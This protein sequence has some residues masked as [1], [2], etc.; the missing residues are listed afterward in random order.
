MAESGGGSDGVGCG[1]FDFGVGGDGRV[2]RED[3]ATV[4]IGGV[5]GRI[6]WRGAW[7]CRHRVGEG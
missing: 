1:D 6:F 3:W 7:R 4:G 2:G 5:E